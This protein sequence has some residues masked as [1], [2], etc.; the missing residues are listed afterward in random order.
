M[1]RNFNYEWN[2]DRGSLTG[3]PILSAAGGALGMLFVLVVMTIV[4]DADEWFCMGTLFSLAATFGMSVIIY[5]MG[6]SKRFTLAVSMGQTRR[7]VISHYFLR[8]TIL[9]I[10]GYGLVLLI[11][12]GEMAL[13]SALYPGVSQKGNFNFLY[14]PLVALGLIGGNLLVV[15]FYGILYHKYGQKFYAISYFVMLGVIL[16]IGKLDKIPWLRKTVA[17][18]P[19][20]AWYIMA[21]AVVA[22]MI[23]GIARMVH[24]LAVK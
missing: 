10:L 20:A 3:I 17:E 23:W 24:T 4:P 21:A 11:H 19:T 13:Y 8:Q 9:L 2:A 1:K 16:L 12:Q 18:V 5:G 14:H 6:F 15:L 22:G 7:S